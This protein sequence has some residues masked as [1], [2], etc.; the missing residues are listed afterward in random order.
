MATEMI[1]TGRTTDQ[2]IDSACEQLGVDRELVEFEILELPKKTLF[3]TTMA[4]VKVTYKR[5]KSQFAEEFLDTVVRQMGFEGTQI[6]TVESEN[7]VTLTLKGEGIGTIIGRRGET[8]DA[9][10]YLTGL[11]ANK[12]DGD[13]FRVTI[14][15]G[16]YRAKR[17][18]TLEELAVRLANNAVKTGRSST[19]E[20]MN[21]YE[22]RVIHSAVQGI[23]GA[24]SSS[25]GEEPNRRV[26][27]SSTNPSKS[28]A[29]RP[30][31]GRPP[32]NKD[33]KPYGDRKPY[34][35]DKKPYGDRKPYESSSR[36]PYVTKDGAASFG[37]G[38]TP[39]QAPKAVPTK[40]AEDKPLYSK[41]EF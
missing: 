16:N 41:I 13:Y 8:L 4:K 9:L 17:E 2:A 15:S 7:C 20:P 23:E 22:R 28:F 29:P 33:R 30:A 39:S 24:T 25:V 38:T 11:V 1:G 26:V 18:K 12:A 6:E 34:S 10:Q 40:E 3:K 35:G 37:V 14:D 27:I 19:L 36:K 5:S 32:Y 21:P 31:G